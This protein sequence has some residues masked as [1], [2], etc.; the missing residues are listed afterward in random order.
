M[1]K[2]KW[3]LVDALHT[4]I[5]RVLDSWPGR[6]INDSYPTMTTARTMHRAISWRILIGLLSGAVLMAALSPVSAQAPLLFPQQTP[7]VALD[8]GHGGKDLGARGPTGLL[9]KDACLALARNLALRLES[10]YRVIL[11]RSDDY[12]VE[13]KQRAAIANQADADLLVSLHT[14]AG[15]LHA[16]R[17][18]AIYYYADAAR[19]ALIDDMDHLVPADDPQQWNR[20]QQR[21]Q[22][23]SLALAT[24]LKKRLDR[25]PDSPGCSIHGAPLAVLE[26]ADMPAVLIEIGHITHPATETR[27]AALQDGGWLAGPIVDGIQDFLAEHTG[28][29]EP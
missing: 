26:G 19:T 23:A 17:G 4:V 29:R 1:S 9:E 5:G 18:I 16:T 25:V 10:H 14:G 28:S 15:Y 11:T 21:H 7:H 2:S 8:P 6:L 24:A 20:T 27:L 12:Q 22:P 3:Q 13:L